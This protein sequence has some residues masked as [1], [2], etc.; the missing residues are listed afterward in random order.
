MYAF[1]APALRQALQRLTTDNAQGEEYLTDVVGAFVAGG[2]RVHA[3]VVD[4]VDGEGVNDREQLARAG[5]ALRDRVVSAALQRGVTV[6]DPATTWLD[7]TVALE[8]DAVIEPFTQLTGATTVAAGA[9]VGPYTRLQDCVVGMGATVLSSI[10]SGAEI[11]DG[12]EVGPYAYLR[13]GTVIGRR[14]KV[15]T[16]VETKNARI[17]DDSK[18]PHL[19]YVGD[20][21]IGER[22][23]IGAATIFVNYDGVTKSRSVIGSDVRVGADNMLVAPLRIGDG[24]YTA[25]GSVL[26]DDVPA[27]AMGVARARQR[28]ID[29]WVERKRAGTRSAES[30]RVAREAA[31]DAAAATGTAATGTAATGTA[32]SGTGPSTTDIHPD[33][34]HPQGEAQ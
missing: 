26:T 7:V 27:G 28:N 18:V 29:G 17:G 16:Y 10:G 11:G 25:A 32:T 13:P 2:L 5:A 1:D 6:V 34:Q 21:E 4:A 24:A 14:A 30:A 15:G 33:Q 22:T 9:V 23:N 19:S 8:P 3:V 20:A 12:A 31:A